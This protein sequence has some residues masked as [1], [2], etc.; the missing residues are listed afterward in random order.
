MCIVPNRRL[1]WSS[2]VGGVI[3]GVHS[4]QPATC[5]SSLVGGVI[6]GVHSSQPA[7]KNF[8]FS[9]LTKFYILWST[10][11]GLLQGYKILHSLVFCRAAGLRCSPA[12]TRE[13]TGRN[14]GS[15]TGLQ[16]SN[17]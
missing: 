17:L 14:V 12:E 5:L 3:V 10:F 2:L 15:A 7:T 16:I 1:A 4:P 9:G 6:V 8:T 11:S 13:C